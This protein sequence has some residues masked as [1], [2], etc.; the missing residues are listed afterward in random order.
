MCLQMSREATN[1]FAMPHVRSLNDSLAA[2]LRGS[3]AELKMS[4]AALATSLDKSPLWVSRRL[5]GTVAL[6]VEDLVT[7]CD[8]LSVDPAEVLA[9]VLPADRAAS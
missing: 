7:I 2:K 1:S 9:S 5:T 3:A 4:G 6:S 8:A